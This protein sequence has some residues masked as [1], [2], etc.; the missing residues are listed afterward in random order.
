MPLIVFLS[1]LKEAERTSRYG[2]ESLPS[3]PWA[4]TE[5]AYLEDFCSADNGSLWRTREIENG[6]RGASERMSFTC[7]Q[8]QG[9]KAKV[10][11]ITT[12]AEVGIRKNLP[13]SNAMS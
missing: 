1:T 3:A 4:H 6:E 10:S 11:R 13:A 8:P 5:T 12:E 2:R 7:K 9:L